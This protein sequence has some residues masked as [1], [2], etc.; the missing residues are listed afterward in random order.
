MSEKKSDYSGTP[1]TEEGVKDWQ[2]SFED[3]EESIEL[4]M[5][6]GEDL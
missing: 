6:N 3:I 4:V 2:K 5:T 1:M